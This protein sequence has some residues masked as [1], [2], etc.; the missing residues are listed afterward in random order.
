VGNHNFSPNGAVLIFVLIC[1]FFFLISPGGHFSNLPL[2]KQ[3]SF[4]FFSSISMVILTEGAK[5]QLFGSLEDYFI[6]F[7]ISGG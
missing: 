3:R 7:E 4:N 2:P 1:F 5:M 6:T